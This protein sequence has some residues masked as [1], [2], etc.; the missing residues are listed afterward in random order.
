MALP[1]ACIRLSCNTS[2]LGAT[3]GEYFLKIVFYVCVCVSVSRVHVLRYTLN[4][5][6]ENFFW[7]VTVKSSRLLVK[8]FFFL[9]KQAFFPDSCFFDFQFS[10]RLTCLSARGLAGM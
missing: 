8:V 2:S 7:M 6:D 3:S 5:V 10:A 9:L 4:K 1:S